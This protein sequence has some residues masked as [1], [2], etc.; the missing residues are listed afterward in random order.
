MSVFA[1]Y[2]Q[3]MFLGPMHMRTPHSFVLSL[4]WLPYL[5]GVPFV[6]GRMVW[7]VYQ[8]VKQARE[9]K[10]QVGVLRIVNMSS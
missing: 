9:V 3:L 10:E 8:W 5:L 1:L 4:F 2:A 6:V 7:E